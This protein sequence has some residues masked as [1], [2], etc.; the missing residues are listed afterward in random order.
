MPHP[1]INHSESPCVAE[2]NERTAHPES[3]GPLNSAREPDSVENSEGQ[4]KAERCLSSAQ[5]ADR[6]VRDSQW[7]YMFARLEAYRREHGHL[8]VPRLFEGVPGLGRWVRAQREFASRGELRADRRA[9]LDAIGF[10]WHAT[11]VTET[12]R[13]EERFA[14]MRAFR[15]RF[16]HCSVPKKWPE[17][18][19]LANWLQQV[20][21]G[22]VKGR[23]S[24]ER[25][26]R[27]EAIGF[28]WHRKSVRCHSR[29]AHWDVMFALLKT[30][31]QPCD[32]LKGPFLKDGDGP[33]LTNWMTTQR[34]LHAHG[35]LRADRHALLETI[36]FPWKRSPI[37]LSLQWDTRFGE[38]RAYASRF[39]HCRVPLEWEEN[40]SLGQWVRRQHVEKNLGRL[41][42][43]QIERLESIGFEWQ[44]LWTRFPDDENWEMAFAQVAEFR[45]KN[46]HLRIPERYPGCL[47]LN[48]WIRRQRNA[49]ER[50]KLSAERWQRLE[51]LGIPRD[52]HAYWRA[53]LWEKRFQELLDFRERFGHCR[54]PSKWKEGRAL[55][56]WVDTQRRSHEKGTMSPER[57]ERLTAIGFQWLD[58]TRHPRVRAENWEAM[59]AHLLEYQREHGHTNVPRNFPGVEGLARWVRRQRKDG[60]SGKLS[61]GRRE[62]LEAVDF[63]WRVRTPSLG[64]P[65]SESP[66]ID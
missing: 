32:T 22:K 55:G 10:V 63:Q 38:L 66:R 62:R 12:Q 54:V 39:G 47:N 48:A 53:Q 35:K 4:P 14:E 64:E 15:E 33:R 57:S 58:K 31:Q 36:G 45:E 43:E 11:R 21:F 20:R 60:A 42:H 37:W 6:L 52:P 23:L 3:L 26:R 28:A 1:Q 59:F 7:D 29:N 2:G 44:P 41:S 27:L 56:I 17:N 61:A 8:E 30:Y 9:R 19:R 51:S 40:K 25:I 24:A 49:W 46:G 13:W 5:L 34:A 16:G 18:P 65:D 50:G